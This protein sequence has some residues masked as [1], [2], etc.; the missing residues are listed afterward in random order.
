LTSEKPIGKDTASAF[1][2]HNLNLGACS[3]VAYSPTV[4]EKLI[5]LKRD[6][7]LLLRLE[8]VYE[9]R[10]IK[11]GQVKNLGAGDVL[12]MK[13]RKTYKYRP[14]KHIRRSL[15]TKAYQHCSG[16]LM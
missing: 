16:I 6:F 13:Q 9:L 7:K 15:D 12:G 5:Q 10:S 11:V 2:I 14:I 3:I 8:L 1:G 4:E